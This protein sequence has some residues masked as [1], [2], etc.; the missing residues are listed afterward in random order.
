MDV[1]VPI[2]CALE[3]QNRLTQKLYFIWVV[4]GQKRPTVAQLPQ[5]Q[6]ENTASQDLIIVAT[7]ASEPAP[8]Q[9]FS[10]CSTCEWFFKVVVILDNT[11]QETDS[12]DNF[13]S[14]GAS[15]HHLDPSGLEDTPPLDTHHLANTCHQ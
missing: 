6:E 2:G 9:Y 1:M 15:K 14:W 8:L 5:T 3:R 12:A 11:P 10:A 4:V 7:N 13:T